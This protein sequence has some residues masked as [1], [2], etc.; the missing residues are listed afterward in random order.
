MVAMERG[1]HHNIADVVLDTH[2]RAGR[3]DA[4]AL[5]SLAADGTVTQ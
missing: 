4:V 5:R 2:V 3:G 1:R